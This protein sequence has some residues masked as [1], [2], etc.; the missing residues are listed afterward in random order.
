MSEVKVV[1]QSDLDNNPGLSEKFS[2]GDTVI[3]PDN[4][5]ITEA[6]LQPKDEANDEGATGPTG[7][8]EQAA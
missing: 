2:V 1:T 5:V 4:G 6:E 3:I 7:P 8:G